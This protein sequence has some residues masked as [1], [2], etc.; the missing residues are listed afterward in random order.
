MSS[1]PSIDGFDQH[2]LDAIN[3]L[4]KV[5]QPSYWGRTDINSV[6]S[7]DIL[8]LSTL[9][10]LDDDDVAIL[11]H[12][13]YALHP[14]A[15]RFLFLDLID[16]HIVGR[17]NRTDALEIFRKIATDPDEPFS[18]IRDRLSKD[19]VSALIEIFSS[20]PNPGNTQDQEC[21]AS[22]LDAFRC[23]SI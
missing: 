18:V 20:I 9:N 21:L 11:L 10:S 6:E 13:M 4:F 15:I 14:D 16:P 17:G 19:E 2:N 1:T 5:E 12:T 3:E 23:L 7:I 22:V 8:Y